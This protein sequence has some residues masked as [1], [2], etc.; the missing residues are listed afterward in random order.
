MKLPIKTLTSG[1]LVLSL[2]GVQ[3]SSA[4]AATNESPTKVNSEAVVNFEEGPLQINHVSDF[5]F[6]KNTASGDDATYFARADKNEEDASNF[7]SVEDHRGTNAGWK[8]TVKQN[9][10]FVDN[11]TAGEIVEGTKEG[12]K[13]ELKGA[14]ITLKNLN[15]SGVKDDSFKPEVSTSDIILDPSGGSIPVATAQTDTGMGSWNITFGDKENADHSIQLDVP[16]TAKK[17]KSVAYVS[18]LTWDLADTP[19]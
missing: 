10:Q 11:Q 16:G 5:N 7:V 2:M 9:Y 19:S 8:L 6:G 14:Q 18:E 12:E 13:I 4:F 3:V 17:I 1:A 15:A